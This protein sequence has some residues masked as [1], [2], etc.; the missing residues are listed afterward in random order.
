MQV[1]CQ[2]LWG[3]SQVLGGLIQALGGTMLVL[4]GL[5]RGLS[6]RLWFQGHRLWGQG[7]WPRGKGQRFWDLHQRFKGHGLSRWTWL[8]PS[9]CLDMASLGLD[10]APL[11]LNPGTSFFNMGVQIRTHIL[12]PHL[13]KGWLKKNL[14]DNG[15][16]LRLLVFCMTKTTLLSFSH[17]PWIFFVIYFFILKLQNTV[18]HEIW[19]FF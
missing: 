4:G 18:T 5:G 8:R 6:Q 17:Y 12:V 9:Q 1:S 15:S 16:T 14:I 10:L 2:D 11:G 19:F 7:Q 13:G 3:S